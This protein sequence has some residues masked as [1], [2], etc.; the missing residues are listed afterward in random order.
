MKHYISSLKHSLFPQLIWCLGFYLLY[1]ILC[2][3]NINEFLIEYRNR[4]YNVISIG[5]AFILPQIILIRYYTYLD[6]H[7]DNNKNPSRV[8]I[9]LFSITLILCFN[10]SESYF[11]KQNEHLTK[12]ESPLL[13]DEKDSTNRFYSFKNISFDTNKITTAIYTYTSKA[14][15]SGVTVEENVLNILFYISCPINE[16]KKDYPLYYGRMFKG[17][18]AINIP[19]EERRKDSLDYAEKAKK[20]FFDKII[21]Q[22]EYYERLLDIKDKKRYL[23]YISLLD[24]FKG[25]IF[26]PMEG[27]FKSRGTSDYLYL[28]ITLLVGIP[29]LFIIFIFADFKHDVFAADKNPE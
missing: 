1:I 20:L 14:L 26:M 28:K 29:L 16:S 3:F 27:S 5:I 2:Y 24:S 6:F 25:E 22:P 10:F 15:S 13:I 21:N 7:L 17:T 18:T 19:F 8:I 4:S 12:I 11:D 23:P 9:F